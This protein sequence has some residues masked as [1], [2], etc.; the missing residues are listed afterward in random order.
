ML[1]AVAFANLIVAAMQFG[2][3]A[4]A[5]ALRSDLGLTTL[6]LGFVL[7]GAPAGLM[8][9]TYGWGVLAD[10]TS[11]R[12]VLTAA[13]VGFAAAALASAWAAHDQPVA[14]LTLLLLITNAFG[15][16]T[17]SAGG[18]A[19]SAVFPQRRH[20][21]VLSIR[22]TAIPIGGFVGGLAVP[23]AVAGASLAWALVG[24]AALGLVVALALW[25]TL[26]HVE[27]VQR[28]VT[29][30]PLPRGRSPLHRPVLWLLAIG[31]SSVAFVQLGIAS[32]LTIQL[33]DDGGLTLSRAALVFAA[34]QLV[35]AAGRVALGIWSDRVRDRLA[36]LRGVFAG[37]FVLVVGAVLVTNP[38]VDGVLLTLILVLSTTWQGVG[39]AAAAS[40]APEGRTGST[41]GMQT[42]L[43]AAAF[44]IAPIVIAFVLH[45]GGWTAVELVLGGMVLVAVAS[46]T[47]AR[48]RRD[49]P[50]SAVNAAASE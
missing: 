19:I 10:H 24:F 7:A 32:F 44:T 8:L 2:L 48:V 35:G 38:S 11:E 34:A 29:T 33:V 43:N 27:V 45:H 30:A 46:L 18:R 4:A 3:G 12:R 49:A 20:G 13:F 47:L 15:S 39:V 9:G 16:A 17:H 25:L 37:V 22:H 6:Q 21:T 31:C 40:L 42:T 28:A 14:L 50:S 41:L 5:P 36:L 1:A 26:A 23:A